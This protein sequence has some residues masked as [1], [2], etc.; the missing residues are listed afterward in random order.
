MSDIAIIGLAGRFPGAKN[1]EEFWKNLCSGIETTKFFTKE[2]L[3]AA[4]VSAEL[5][6]DP[7][8]V[9]ASPTLDGVELFD[10]E[11]FGYSRREAE[12]MDPQQ[13][14]FL[15]TAWSTLENAGYSTEA[16][17]GS[18]G[19]FAGSGG[20]VTSYLLQCL[21]S[22]PEIRGKTGGFQHLGNDKD[23]LTT[24]ASYKLNLRGPSV[25]V[26]SAC[27]TSLVSL[28]MACQ[29][30]LSGE[31]DMA[32]A[33]GISVRIP[34][35]T[36]Y[37]RQEGDIYSKD[38]HCRAF[39]A[40]ASGIVFGSGV[41]LVLVKKL[42][43]AIQDKDQIYAV[44]K[45]SAINNDGGAKMS[46]TASSA[47]GQVRC[48]T[49]A[50]TLSDIDPSTI[51]YVEAHGTGTAMGDPVEVNSLTQAF[52]KWTDKKSFCALASVKS[53]LGHLDV[54]AGIT[55]L[56]KV[57][58][59]LHHQKIPPTINFSVPNPKINFENTPFFVNVE[60]KNWERKDYPRRAAVN[61]LGIGGTNA[62][63]ILEEAPEKEIYEL[64]EDRNSHLLVLSGKSVVALNEM[65]KN[66]VD[67]LKQ[68]PKMNI[69]DLCFTA[70]VGRDHFRERLA[71]SG[72]STE[73]LRHQIES[74][75][76]NSNLNR[77]E[78]ETS[79]VFV[80]DFILA[81]E[82]LRNLFCTQSIFQKIL[83][84]CEESLL[85]LG[86][87][88]FLDSVTK[89]DGKK[90]ELVE[91]FAVQFSIA[92]MFKNFGLQ[93][94]F[95]S[96]EP[97]GEL[98]VSGINED[99]P[100]TEV[101]QK[102]QIQL[103][104]EIAN[105]SQTQKSQKASTTL[106]KLNEV[107]GW[108]DVQKI[109]GELYNLRNEIH[110]TNL[111]KST[112]P[113]WRISLPT[114][115]FQ[116]KKYWIEGKQNK[117]VS[118]VGAQAEPNSLNHPV[119]KHRLDLADGKT[120]FT[121]SLDTSR[122]NFLNDHVVYNK[123]IV[124][125]SQFIDFAAFCFANL[126][127]SV[128]GSVSDVHFISPL[129][130]EDKS[131]FEIQVVL[132]TDKKVS[133]FEIFS[134]KTDDSSKKSWTAHCRGIVKG[135]DPSLAENKNKQFINHKVEQLNKIQNLEKIYS[136]FQKM[137]LNYG[138]EFQGIKDVWLSLDKTE[139]L[140]K[141]EILPAENQHWQIN[142][143]L[144]D[145]AF[146]SCLFPLI[147]TSLKIKL[148]NVIVPHLI[149]N[150]HFNKTQNVQTCYCHIKSIGK[151][152]SDI[153]VMNIES[154]VLFSVQSYAGIEVS[155]E[156]LLGTRTKLAP[157]TSVE[158]WLF[159][160]TW[161]IQDLASNKSKVSQTWLLVTSNSDFS[162][163]LLASLKG[164]DIKIVVA[165]ASAE[166]SLYEIIQE[167]KRKHP[168]L[169]VNKVI[170]FLSLDAIGLNKTT[171][172][173]EISRRIQ[174]S[175]GR[176]L[177]LTKI[178]SSDEFF[179]KSE[180]IFVTQGGVTTEQGS[181]AINL[182]QCGIL[183]LAK[184]FKSENPAHNCRTID[185][186]KGETFV[187]EDVRNLIA[188]INS[189]SSED[190]VL[191][192][193]NVRKVLRLKQLP[194]L[195][196]DFNFEKKNVAATCL[197]TGGL[198]GLGFSMAEFYS[199]QGFNSIVLV[200]RSEQ[201][202]DFVFKIAEFIKK[203]T[204]LTY[205]R[206][207]IS[208]TE[209]VAEIFKQIENLGLPPI[210]FILHA[211]GKLNDAL[212]RNQSWESFIP[213]YEP[214]VLGAWNLHVE[215]LKLTEPLDQFILFSSIAPLFG[216][217]GQANYSVAN[218]FLDQLAILRKS[219]G[220]AALSVAWGPWA[221]VGMASHL[222]QT[223]SANLL[224]SGFG[225]LSPERA[226][227][228]L[229]K[230]ILSNPSAAHVAIVDINWTKFFA[231]REKEVDNEYLNSFLKHSGSDNF[232]EK[233]KHAEEL[234]SS[235][236]VQQT[237][238]KPAI[239]K[240][241]LRDI[242]EQT[243]R[244]VLAL[245]SN[246]QVDSR[247]SFSNMGLDSLLSVEFMSQL[248]REISKSVGGFTVSPTVIYN[249]PNLNSLTEFLVT[250]IM[251]A[252]KIQAISD[253]VA[254]RKVDLTPVNSLPV[255][256]TA[257]M[258]TLENTTQT[259]PQKSAVGSEFENSIA[260][261]GIGC[262]F[263]G[264]SH[265]LDEYWKYLL[266]GTSAISEIPIERWDINK[267]YSEDKE[268]PGKSYARTGGFLSG[269]DIKTFDADFFEISESAAKGMDPQLRMLMEVT[270]DALENSGTPPSQI[271]ESK[272]GIYV[273]SM[274][275]DYIEIVRASQ[276][277]DDL[278]MYNGSLA[279]ADTLAGRLAYYLG[280]FGPTLHT[281][282]ACS[283][284][285]VA[286]HLACQA[287]KAGEC[288]VALAGG[289]NA[290]VSPT[291][292]SWISKL[293][294]L[295]PSGQ[296]YSFDQRADGYVRAEGCGMLVLKR[297]SDAI[298]NNDQ[299]VGII[300]ATGIGHGGR[301]SSPTA[302]NGLAQEVLIADTLKVAGLEPA[303]VG[304]LEAHATATLLG[305]PIEINAAAKV[306]GLNR[307]T[308]EP[309]LLGSAK[310][311][312]GHMEGAAGVAGLIRAV[313]SLKNKI[314]PPQANFK[315]LN[316][317][318]QLEDSNITIPREATTFPVNKG[319]RI[320][321]VSSFGM[322]GI[323]AHAVLEEAP[324]TK[325]TLKEI[326]REFHLL[327][328]SAR[329]SKSL[330][331]LA[332]SYINF[333]KN[334]PET[335]LADMC[336]TATAGRDHYEFRLSV[337]GKT[338]AEITNHLSSWLETS[339]IERGISYAQIY[340]AQVN[341]ENLPKIAFLFSGQG[342]Q[343][344]GMGKKLYETQAVFRKSLNHC[345]LILK[346]YL[347]QPLLDLIFNGADET[348]LL[349]QTKY[350]QPALF[351]L[352]YSL[353]EMWKSF[354]ITP[355][356]VMGHSVGELVAA[357]VAEV[358][359]LEDGLM[360]ISRRAEL[361]QKL[362]GQ[363]SMAAVMA[364][365]ELVIETLK[366]FG[367]KVSVAAV[368]GPTSMT[369]SGFVPD[370]NE[371]LIYFE[372]TNV[373]FKR[374]SVSHAFH[375]KQMDEMLLDFEQAAGQ[376]RFSPPKI[377]LIS[378]LN[379][380]LVNTEVCDPKYWSQHVRQAVM[381]ADGIR[382]L[383]QLGIKNYIEMGPGSTLVG[384]ATTCLP[385]N[386]TSQ[387]NS[388]LRRGREDWE[389][390]A[391]GLGSLYVQ[392]FK[393]DW[394]NFES[395]MPQ[396]HRI[397]LPT[398][399]FQR[400]TYWVEEKVLAP[401]DTGNQKQTASVRLV[402]EPS[403][404]GERNPAAA[405]AGDFN[406]E[407]MISLDSHDFLKDH[408]VYGAAVVPGATYLE[409]SAA[410]ALKIFGEGL[411]T[412]EDLIIHQ[413]LIIPP[414]QTKLV[415][416]SVQK[417]SDQECQ[418]SI[419]SQVSGDNQNK[420][421]THVTGKI[422]AFDQA[423]SQPAN[424]QNVLQN[425]AREISSQQ[426]YD[427]FT[428]QGIPYGNEFK[429]VRQVKIGSKD[430]VGEVLLHNK[431]TASSKQYLMHPALLDGCLQVGN[432]IISEIISSSG[433]PFGLYLPFSFESWQFVQYAGGPIW[434]HA[435]HR[436][437][438]RLDQ[439]IQMDLVIY[440][441]DGALVA[442]AKGYSAVEAPRTSLLKNEKAANSGVQNDIYELHWKKVESLI[443]KKNS[444]LKETWVIFADAS[445]ECVGIMLTAETAG[446]KLIKIY[447]TQDANSF[448][449]EM[450]QVASAEFPL[451]KV[452]YFWNF[453]SLNELFNSNQSYD[454]E[455]KFISGF[456]S[457]LK[458]TQELIRINAQLSGF[459]IFTREAQSE[460][461]QVEYG[462]L[463][464]SLVWGLGNALRMEHPELNSKLIDM[465]KNTDGSNIS[466][467]F[468][469]ITD[470]NLEPQII[471]KSTERWVRRISSK[472]IKAIENFLDLSG[473]ATYLVTG[474]LG[475]LGFAWAQKL[476]DCGAQNLVLLGRSV[477]KK[478]ITDWIS[479]VEKSGVKVLVR[480]VDV[481]KRK[482]LSDC[483][484]EIA[485][486][487]PPLKGIFH[488]AGVSKMETLN[489]LSQES[490]QSVFQAKVYGAW[491]LHLLSQNLLL[492]YFVMFSSAAAFMPAAGQGSYAAA[493]SFVDALIH[494]RKNV[495]LPGHSFNWGI[496][497]EVG[498]AA[499]NNDEAMW[500]K[501]GM[502][503]IP[504]GDGVELL[505]KLIQSEAP[506]LTI[507]K[508]DWKQFSKTLDEVAEQTFF[509][510]VLPQQENMQK[511]T[512]PNLVTEAQ[513]TIPAQGPQS[514]LQMKLS[515]SVPSEIKIVLIQYLIEQLGKLISKFDGNID[516][517]QGLMSLGL[518][519]LGSIELRNRLKK[520][521]KMPFSPTLIFNYP[522]VEAL[523]DFILSQILLAETTVQPTNATSITNAEKVQTVEKTVEA[524]NTPEEDGIAIIGVGC[525][526]PGDVD[527]L[528]S[529]WKVISNGVDTLTE[530]P[531]SRFDI[532]KYYSK[533]PNDKG[534]IYLKRGGFLNFKN[535]ENFD[536]K[537]FGISP[538]EAKVLDP[539][540]R[541]LLETVWEAI[542]NA[543][544]IPKNLIGTR[545]GVFIGDM[546]QDYAEL[547][548]KSDKS[549]AD[550]MY[551]IMGAGLSA[552]AG[553]I[554]YTMGFEGPS[555]TIDTA[556]SSS[557]VAIHLA[558]EALRNNSADRA[559]AG[560]VNVI[561]S[562]TGY[563]GMSRTRAFSFEG[564]CATFDETADGYVRGEGCGVLLLRRLSD[565]LRDKN[566][567][568]GIIRGSAVNQDG[569]SV[570][571]T[572]PNGLAQEK[573]IRAALQQA[574]MKPDE[575]SYLEAHGTG[576]SLGDP[577]ESQS[578][579]NVL[580]EGRSSNNPLMIGS[581]KTNF[582][583]T[584]A[585]AGVAGI[586]KVILAMRHRAIP[587]H[588]HF[589]KLNPK[590]NLE[591]IPA[592]ILTQL[593]SWKSTKKL[594]A[595]ISSFGITG[596]N[597]HVIL[598]EPPV[599]PEENFF[600]LN[601]SEDYLLCLSARD[602]QATKDLAQKYSDLLTTDHT[603]HQ[604]ASIC[605][606]A[607]STRSA[608]DHRLSVV[609]SS[610]LD[611]VNQLK[612]FISNEKNSY[613]FSDEYK[614]SAESRKVGFF[615][616][617]QNT[618][619]AEMGAQLFETE[620]TFRKSIL[621]CSESFRRFE[622][623][624]LTD[625]LKQKQP[626]SDYSSVLL[627][628]IQYSL[629]KMWKNYG[630][631]ASIVYGK[632]TGQFAAA[633]V[634]GLLNLDDAIKLS[635]A[636]S[637]IQK[638]S[639][640]HEKQKVQ[641]VEVLQ[642]I[643]FNKTEISI[644]SELFGR[645]FS[646]FE[647]SDKNQWLQYI[648]NS[649]AAEYLNGS[650]IEQFHFLGIGSQNFSL[651]QP[652]LTNLKSG[653]REKK[654]VLAILGQLFNLGIEVQWNNVWNL[655]LTSS[656]QKLPT[657]PFQRQKFWVEPYIILKPNDLSKKIV[658]PEAEKVETEFVLQLKNA[659]DDQ[660]YSLVAEFLKAQINKTLG[661]EKSKVINET[662]DFLSLGLDSLSL[663]NLTSEIKSVFTT[664][665]KIDHNLLFE[666]SSVQKLSQYICDSIFLVAG[667][668]IFSELS[669]LKTKTNSWIKIWEPNSSA[670]IRLV[671]FHYAGG[672]ALM[673]R[674]WSQY[675][676]SEIELCAVQLPGRWERSHE[677]MQSLAELMQPLGDALIETLD[678]PSVFFGYSM[679]GG[680]AFEAARELRRRGSLLPDLLIA[681]AC[682]AP[683]MHHNSPISSFGPMSDEAFIKRFKNIF[684]SIYGEKEMQASIMKDA[685][686]GVLR[687][688]MNA[689]NT[690]SY[691]EEIPFDFPI[692]A[693]GGKDDLTLSAVK[694]EQ[695]K[696]QTCS[697]FTKKEFEGGHLFIHEIP[698]QELVDFVVKQI[699]LL[700][701]RQTG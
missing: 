509:S 664:D 327:V 92:Q 696:Q 176:N 345:A 490:Y 607:I 667:S 123:I 356:A 142:P 606:A 666:K 552:V 324:P 155:E 173:D 140:T 40:D 52:R 529:F 202:D 134:R 97:V 524:L 200:G 60:L 646:D 429:V 627:F 377:P 348:S 276:D 161:Q 226:K 418:W 598:E 675:L 388:S 494:V 51:E 476:V 478:E 204:Q 269:I 340:S 186:N 537:F 672:S 360:L 25:A 414:E 190:H 534:K 24:R 384:M 374:L 595:G 297:Y 305:D 39:D 274:L 663:V 691:S 485:E 341:G 559:I 604:I 78:N 290:L 181:K 560:G 527:S 28:H 626:S 116:R 480:S 227:D 310:G 18:I 336:F 512:Q 637:R 133:G 533:D 488:A 579:G 70:A 558:C 676:P 347:D 294:V 364:A 622:S 472:K 199:E 284:S 499:Q 640:D 38:G 49:E 273:G 145:C 64:T 15:E 301:A 75:Q 523:A 633:C 71:F 110:W 22:F 262:R 323:M 678:R 4:G 144:L 671:C 205:L 279:S 518:D 651:T 548:A 306:F 655:S 592:K 252:E 684:G 135:K 108:A 184:T 562:P 5:L 385:E 43:D 304:Y 413:P 507:M 287:L 482:A 399:P 417:T 117:D 435:I 335:N 329:N 615:F 278:E 299:I 185:L 446:A 54:A 349:H 300:R 470:T 542:E 445:V 33:G 660:R 12:Y 130:I 174:L 153:T 492:D 81:S 178:F 473:T 371:V 275:A 590:I 639:S 354:G 400:K 282:T 253:E 613:V 76:K 434:C 119:L 554:S 469:E 486:K 320:A 180:I 9:M 150:V 353:S 517:T 281:N 526:Y 657:Y 57:V 179:D 670:S 430:V 383:N 98:F 656:S 466:S 611:L 29:S 437:E 265:N 172:Q 681:A 182:S 359:S 68:H 207:D 89:A 193:G 398:Y 223:E 206:A 585:A 459:Y 565:A 3:L 201:P 597:A 7:D 677:P 609:G 288:N 157:A 65:A 375:S 578:F 137:G 350:T 461:N 26:Q 441:G 453:Q 428:R 343:Y 500:A 224:D 266:K 175:Y 368:N 458:I 249:Y 214:K 498:M 355:E 315:I 576:T 452:L 394:K 439:P 261:V 326:D 516:I 96:Q 653:A 599:R 192:E 318:I 308:T 673:Y 296:S 409:M 111:M 380:R 504:L 479:K 605:Y 87:S 194:F 77:A 131:E 162:A 36:G 47:S 567:I 254:R 382:S 686:I 213:V 74:W 312:F 118:K 549:S 244:R 141:I 339:Q 630:I 693:V 165:L 149:S 412:V 401:S 475:G 654:H 210:K 291:G 346:K 20:V 237:E 63:F 682:P 309:L 423:L 342:S 550:E 166:N 396:R 464:Q 255:A 474:G 121:G 263:P 160:Q 100:L 104:T 629:A 586:I 58:L 122:L 32:M 231:A 457:I 233:V 624:S 587:P 450:S 424:L 419:A 82:N 351:A 31:C 432:N 508:V 302:P 658:V 652:T 588:L 618:I 695:W 407:S 337:S 101:F 338:S 463:P 105:Q 547:I 239:E 426:H 514:A 376:V 594:V 528:E 219:Q 225:F 668:E 644:F 62:F 390:L 361:M 45:G 442:Q 171:R 298:A 454:A 333:L 156:M 610:K 46:Y 564:R 535:L 2:E 365:P 614:K 449:N 102:A 88:Q 50:L 152:I 59:S 177:E 259:I 416:T 561:L 168:A 506:Q 163:E 427:V 56:I 80:K 245:D 16:Y 114:Y 404:L 491:N 83:I 250:K 321:G 495:G 462:S 521:L 187:D 628:S 352:E 112:T 688:D 93:V 573:L 159:Q 448:V 397:S 103:K 580:K 27:S 212:L 257:S 240:D 540:Q 246:F 503:G 373:L 635:Y 132:T 332:Q 698:T 608:F 357:C 616:P 431:L 217:H 94:P 510:T 674:E 669:T 285:L 649:K 511:L 433:K 8:Y 316:S 574:K 531:L 209:Q 23:F 183:S 612:S 680:F 363:G 659:A 73:E 638:N 544:E 583:H 330:Q 575:V 443:E 465:G 563:I 67:I 222:K 106:L 90:L 582:G 289:V 317:N 566:P 369:I 35:Q 683:Q 641:F 572:A 21:D 391:L 556:C 191:Y 325:P 14:I 447:Q 619:Y 280:S 251:T 408:L 293:G 621:D 295:S 483:F 85:N 243:L 690:Y 129:I 167:I 395:E 505:S 267:H 665:V 197:I 270:W 234:V 378:N 203:G 569:K 662:K 42:E 632:G 381:F 591:E 107:N 477:P 6:N 170:S 372:K 258:E 99:L 66:Y 493:N 571:M 124:P 636:F 520:D 91:S 625:L 601:I 471:L 631:S 497:S 313:L 72:R 436:G 61:G 189:N 264:G 136:I 568:L 679:G 522:T 1:I 86:S 128:A 198:G 699:V 242:C 277:A 389:D 109:V 532:Q 411:H 689:L 513:K 589:K 484:S 425:C 519:S 322:S 195:S 44:I 37:L 468:A 53:N 69:G 147:D 115:P 701:R 551:S 577:I 286:I 687:N 247:K 148:E 164:T 370:L 215:S 530:I 421:V 331:E 272:A 169:V 393:I 138:K 489:S 188:E 596:T 403:F 19:I 232:A 420:W 623:V 553:R 700:R 502:H 642:E 515:S 538:A 334:N 406:F 143:M 366:N 367:N 235:S 386:H 256:P 238:P 307:K 127:N 440:D 546:Y 17:P 620:A 344:V 228:V 30:V 460:K 303:H 593:T 221:D 196:S 541:I 456:E 455:K 603:P 643:N 358:F 311:N 10:A 139:V 602:S 229:Q 487:L 422:K 230:A 216:N 248:K 539:A 392:G 438:L 402:K 451:T 525:R 697:V 410:A 387:L 557:L 415:R 581:V 694:L 236:F 501:G 11:F 543:G 34:Q 292:Y 151:N 650:I 444:F 13:R 84:E 617:D 405:S 208:K 218:S 545:T 685:W 645:N 647:L 95:T 570:T 328:L 41:G 154:E 260:I 271:F 600:G 555:M 634:S 220:L 319:K 211:A 379:A 158:N 692:T 268:E 125:G 467:L 79:F 113:Y 126:Q 481:A 283:S 314:V 584:E 496:W 55:S 661:A 536:A 48:M 146:Q 120:V 648:T 362:T 241:K